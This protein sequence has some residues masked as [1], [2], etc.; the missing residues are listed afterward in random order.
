[1]EYEMEPTA[2]LLI[3]LYYIDGDHQKVVD[4]ADYV[5]QHL[6]NW[7]F[8]W[9]T[10]QIRIVSLY[11]VGQI[12]KACNLSLALL[13]HITSSFENHI[14]DYGSKRVMAAKKFCEDNISG[15]G[16]SK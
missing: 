15:M 2:I 5:N 16:C 4:T 3:E 9:R 11:K 6:R 10:L 1:M 8:T 12:D 13:D 14:Q 7:A